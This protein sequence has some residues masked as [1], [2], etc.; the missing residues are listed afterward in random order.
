MIQVGFLPFI[1][2]I[3]PLL[4]TP[5]MDFIAGQSSRDSSNYIRYA[6]A[7]M[8]QRIAAEKDASKQTPKDFMHYLLNAKDPLTG[9]GLTTTELNSESSLLISA[10]SDTTSITISATL[11]YL[12]HYPVSLAKTTTEV[13]NTFA[14]VNE[15]RGGKIL[16]GLVYLRACIDEALRLSP[17]VPSHLP[18][19]V[20]PGGL[21]IDGHYFPKGTVVGTAPYAIHH[22]KEYFPEPFVFRPERWIMDDNPKSVAT[23]RAAFFSFSLGPRGCIGKSIAYI[24][25]TLALATLLFLYDIRLP[26][27]TGKREPSGEGKLNN[28]HWGRRRKDEYQLAEYFLSER[29]GPMVEFKAR[30]P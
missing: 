1:K 16:N 14:S 21:T 6:N 8:E 12:L 15:I 2:L 24:E 20:L 9:K 27:D 29:E 25:A 30:L 28:K 7:Q 13:R 23:A 26:E 10:G 22:C 3:R 5:I 17:P 11:F 4:G 19:E 18:R